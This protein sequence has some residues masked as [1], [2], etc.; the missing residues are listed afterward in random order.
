MDK[1]VS[2]PTAPAEP[3]SPSERIERINRRLTDDAVDAAR[4]RWLRDS[5][6][7]EVKVHA[8]D[9]VFCEVSHE[10]LDAAI[11]AAMSKPSPSI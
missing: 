6:D 8:G 5:V 11:D 9:G 4:Y 3:E 2:E 7:A 10:Y 1:P